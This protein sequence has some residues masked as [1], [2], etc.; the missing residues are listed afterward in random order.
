[1]SKLIVLSIDSL[2]DE[3]MDFLRKE[4]VKRAYHQLCVLLEQNKFAYG[5]YFWPP[6]YNGLDDY[7]L[8]CQKEK[9]RFY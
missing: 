7:C 9:I 4:P 8:A 6:K 1:M 3:D 5:S 2:F